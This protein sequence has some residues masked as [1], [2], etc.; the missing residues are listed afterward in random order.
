MSD[1]SELVVLEESGY[2]GEWRIGYVAKRPAVGDSEGRWYYVPEE[3]IVPQTSK[4][5]VWMLQDN[6]WSCL[7][8][9]HWNAQ[10]TPA[11][12]PDEWL[13]NDVAYDERKA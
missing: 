4:S 5:L 12:S 8:T 11:T 13:K 3:T 7:H 2:D 1:N 9:M 6:E 10:V